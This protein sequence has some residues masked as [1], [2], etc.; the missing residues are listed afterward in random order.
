MFSVKD[1]F[2]RAEWS[3]AVRETVWA[4]QIWVV[5]LSH[6]GSFQKLAGSGLASMRRELLEAEHFGQG[7]SSI[8][9]QLN[10]LSIHSVLL[11]HQ[12]RRLQ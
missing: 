10:R 8:A 5:V 3:S 12:S 2:R 7:G 11:H 4:W 6:V 1:G 9:S